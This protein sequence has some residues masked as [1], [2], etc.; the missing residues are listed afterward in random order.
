MHV[1]VPGTKYHSVN[2]APMAFSP[3]D[4]HTLYYGTQFLMKTADAGQTWQEISPDLTNV[5]GRPD[6]ARAPQT[7]SITTF[8]VSAVT[9]GVIWAGTEQRSRADDRRRRR[10]VEERDAA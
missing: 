7:P 4:P 3:H 2:N 1:F 10:D 5:P 6:T 9:A 8:S